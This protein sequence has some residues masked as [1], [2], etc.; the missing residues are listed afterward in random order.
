MIEVR[1]LSKHFRIRHNPLARL[2]HPDH[3][4]RAVDDVT[5]SIA[6]GEVIGLAGESGCGKT[7]LAKTLVRLYLPSSGEV[8]YQ[9]RDVFGMGRR[10]LKEFRREVQVIF[11]DSH[12]ALD[13]RMTV[14]QAL[15]EPLRL[16]RIGDGSL[17]ERRLAEIMD[18]VKLSPAFLGR[19]PFELSGGQRQRV[20]VA[21]ALLLEP[22]LIIADEPLAGLDPVVSTQLLSLML[23]IRRD[24]GIAYL[25]ISHDLNT[26]AYASDR[27]AV[28][29]RGRIVEIIE[30]QRFEAEAGH[31]YTRFL[32]A[33]GSPPANEIEP[34][35]DIHG[36]YAP[37][38]TGC[39]FHTRCPRST[40]LCV[41]SQPGLSDMAS[42]HQVACHYP[43]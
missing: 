4:I 10:E 13:P 11:Q 7:T 5:F 12:S 14:R 24:H 39:G 28:M 9:G 38:H 35:P 1:K 41:E 16:H 33:S 43:G 23:N 19:H 37:R 18:V 17:R 36:H 30:G 34:A 31:P 27:V 26:I 20:T 2:S 21:R 25:L 22:R 32:L 3:I 40:E 6:R 8:I 15:E 29:Y 42:G